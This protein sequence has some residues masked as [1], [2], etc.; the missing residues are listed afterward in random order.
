[1]SAGRHAKK[2]GAGAAHTLALVVA[3]KIYDT[4]L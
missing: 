3:S 1:M 2:K 4:E